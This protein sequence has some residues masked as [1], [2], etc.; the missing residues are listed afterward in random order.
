[1]LLQ[2]SALWLFVRE[3]IFAPTI[4][5]GAIW[6]SSGRLAKHLAAQVP[7][8]SK[9]LIIELGAGTGVVTQALIA[10]GVNPEKLVVVERH[11]PDVQYLRAHFPLIRVIQGDASSLASLL[12]SDAIVDYIVSS[13]PLRSLPPRKVASIIGQ[14]RRVLAPKGG[15]IQF[16]YDLRRCRGESIRG[17]AVQASRIIWRNIPPARVLTM[18]SVHHSIPHSSNEV[19]L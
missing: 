6:P 18:K 4:S 7:L 1:M 15:V 14:W 12:P 9:G 16:T 2:R 5:V 10:R 11:P 13:L 3:I 19:K 17:F 8:P